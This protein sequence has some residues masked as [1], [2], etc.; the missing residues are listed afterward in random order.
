MKRRNTC[1]SITKC[2]YTNI[3]QFYTHQHATFSNLLIV[4]YEIY[5]QDLIVM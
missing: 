2:I 3:N 4:S 5:T 1:Y